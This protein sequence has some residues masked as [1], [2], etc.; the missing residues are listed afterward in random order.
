M[1][2]AR[3]FAAGGFENL[4][5]FPIE[6]IAGF[7]GALVPRLAGVVLLEAGAGIDDQQRAH[8]F[9]MGTVERQRHIAAER[10]PADD[11]PGGTDFIEQ[12]RHVGY[13]LSLAIGS[14]IARV[15]GLAVAAHVPQHEFVM[16]RKCGDLALPHDLVIDA[17]PV[18][19]DFRH[20][21]LPKVFSLAVGLIL[22]RSGRCRE[23]RRRHGN[24]TA[25]Q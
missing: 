7:T 25:D 23:M 17:D 22:A 10:E 9:G 2:D 16:F 1:G 5:T 24:P 15:I 14:V 13:R 4:K 6:A 20:R 11:R 19:I 12:R 21:G 3:T 18:A 8:A